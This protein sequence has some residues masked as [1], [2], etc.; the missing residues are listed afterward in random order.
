MIAKS[1][2]KIS[3]IL[4]SGS[5]RPVRILSSDFTGTPKHP[6]TNRRK[7]IVPDVVADGWP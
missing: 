5:S 1:E 6:L 7:Q 3:E 4:Y 2:C